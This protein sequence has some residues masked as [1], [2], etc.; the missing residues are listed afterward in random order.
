MSNRL[1]KFGKNCP[2]DNCDLEHNCPYKQCFF[3]K[4]GSECKYN[5]DMT[6]DIMTDVPSMAA[7]AAGTNTYVPPIPSPYPINEPSMAAGTM[8]SV[9]PRPS[10][11]PI[12]EPSMA[13]GTMASVHPRP[14][15]YPIDDSMAHLLHIPDVDVPPEDAKLLFLKD[16]AEG[17][18]TGFEN[19]IKFFQA[20]YND[21]QLAYGILE[22]D[23]EYKTSHSA[24]RCF[25]TR[26]FFNELFDDHGSVLTP[27]QLQLLQNKGIPF[28]ITQFDFS[29]TDFPDHTFL[30]IYNQDNDVYYLLQ[31]YY[32]AYTFGGKYGFIKLNRKAFNDFRAL[33]QSYKECSGISES[34]KKPLI[35]QLNLE[36]Q[37]YTGINSSK[38]QPDMRVKSGPNIINITEQTT[39][40]ERLLGNTHRHLNKFSQKARSTRLY[41]VSL[42]SKLDR[43]EIYD[44]F[45]KGPLSDWNEFTEYTGFSQRLMVQL[46][47]SSGQYIF[48]Y[49]DD[50]VDVQINLMELLQSIRSIVRQIDTEINKL[51]DDPAYRQGRKIKNKQK[52]S[53]KIKNVGKPKK[54]SK[55][56]KNVG[57]PKKQ[58]KK[59]QKHRSSRALSLKMKHTR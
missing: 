19:C 9:H 28:F 18:C 54:Q 30:F 38:H 4:F 36:L 26:E 16:S 32:F 45:T 49:I 44:A 56:I 58:S 15:P 33:I 35:R 27:S 37:K 39:T 59:I 22:D 21:I 34:S 5:H 41:S 53:K 12:D 24:T 8:A 55:K 13:A 3:D 46:K 50:N 11:Y 6:D 2:I 47:F 43:Y 7:G 14:S 31:S 42:P 25:T 10:P 40:L 57:K 48:F 20:K 17:E 23:E 1:C 29:G 52:R 51:N